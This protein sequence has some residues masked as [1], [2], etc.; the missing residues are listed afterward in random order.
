MKKN[1]VYFI[2]NNL[3][4]ELLQLNLDFLYANIDR[5][6]TETLVIAAKDLKFSKGDAKPDHIFYVDSFD[7]KYHAKYDLTKWKYVSDYENF[8]YL[9][10]DAI[11]IRNIENAFKACINRPLIVHSAMENPSIAKSDKNHRFSD[12]VY[13]DHIIS[14]N[15]GQFGFS[16]QLLPLFEEFHVYIDEHKEKAYHDQSLFNEYFIQKGVIEPTYSL[17]TYFTIRN[18]K[19]P[20]VIPIEEASI[21]HFFGGTFEGKPANSIEKF[22]KARLGLTRPQRR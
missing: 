7:Y 19:V 14:Y 21:V 22:L 17:L 3:Y 18:W 5:S 6:T 15:A 2:C 1:L 4:K 11:V 20:N 9:D 16:K 13:P 12:F 10:V 8:L